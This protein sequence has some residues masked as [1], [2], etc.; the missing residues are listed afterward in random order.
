MNFISGKEQAANS[1]AWLSNAQPH[2]QK[3]YWLA[4]F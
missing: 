3:D 4:S 1:P 2:P